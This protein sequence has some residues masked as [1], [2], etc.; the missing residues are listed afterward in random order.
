VRR[1]RLRRSRLLRRHRH[2][3]AGY[4]TGCFGKWHLGHRAEFLPPNHGFDESLVIPYSHD[5]YRGAPWAKPAWTA[6]WPDAI[7]LL[8]GAEEVDQLRGPKGLG[9]LTE[10]FTTAAC[11]F[12]SRHA[13]KPFFLYVPQ[14]LPHQEIFSPARWRGTAARSPYGDAV[15]ELDAAVGRILAILADHGLDRTTLVVVTSDNG[16]A[17]VY[18]KDLP[19]YRDTRLQ[20]VR[21][22]SWKL[23][24]PQRER[25]KD[26]SET[27][28]PLRLC[29]LATDV[30]EPRDVA[31]DHAHVVAAIE[32]AAKG[33]RIPRRTFPP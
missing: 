18:Q 23:W 1:P 4:A 21:M 9:S 30:G 2:H 15:A 22:G 12:I 32:A 16:P 3:A 8:R 24:L 31:A 7:P 25:S 10:R 14:P 20:A 29:D 13:G 26:G 27:L 17:N 33:V 11:D 6:A 28:H 5:M 19:Y